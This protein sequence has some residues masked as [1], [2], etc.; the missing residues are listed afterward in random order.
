VLRPD[1]RVIRSYGMTLAVCAAAFGLRVAVEPAIGGQ[2]PFVAFYVAVTVVAWLYGTG[3]AVF[4]TVIGALDARYF[5]LRA[6]DS[7]RVR[8]TPDL[9]GLGFYLLVCST[10]IA[11]LE[12]LRRA[13]RR[14]EGNARIAAERFEQLRIETEE[15]NRIQQLGEQ[16]RRWAAVTLANIG[17]A[18]VSTDVGNR[19][20]FMNEVA[21]SLTGW[22]REEARGRPIEEVFKILDENTG[23]PVE[24]PVERVIR[25]GRATGLANHTVLLNRNGFRIPIEDSAAPIP[26]SDGKPAGVVLAFRDISAQRQTER[27]L[28]K[29]NEDLREF[30]YVASHDLQE[31]L[32]MIGSFLGLLSRRYQ[33]RLDAK[34]DTYIR[35]A[36]EGAKRMQELV[37][38]LLVYSRAGTQAPVIRR[39]SCRAVLERVLNMLEASIRESGAQVMHG[40]L[41]EVDADEIK[42]GQ[43]FQNLIGNAIKFRGERA[44][45]IEI[46]V[47]PGEREWIFSVNDNCMGFEQRHAERIFAMFQRLHSVGEYPGS[48]I[49]L[50]LAKR[51]IEAH[52]GRM[53]AQ[54][55]PGAGSTFYFTLPLDTS[56]PASM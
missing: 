10:V 4:T 6:D 13:R 53:W 16:H 29:S 36:I 39:V 48:G 34:A 42:L 23:Q 26:D 20:T 17:E 24:I 3:P 9:A 43:V 31:P 55:Q 35:Y 11:A 38:S 54:S 15:R 1:L 30:A 27:A 46:R 5:F 50:A 40:D 47:V 37:Q 19:V 8:H 33:G 49:G 41:P 2:A 51:L 28:E 22:R 7:I 44:P 25:E 32:R 56:L 45:V 18:V 21:E 14:A 52:G 12:A